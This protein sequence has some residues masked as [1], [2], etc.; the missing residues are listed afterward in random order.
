MKKS[1]V[2]KKPKVINITNT[3]NFGLVESYKALRTNIMFSLPAKENVRSRKI[4][5]TSSG[6]GEGKSTTTVNLALT[7]AETETK[8][9]LIDADMRKPTVHKY[10]DIES[11]VGL[12]NLLSGMNTAEECIQ[13]IEGMPNLSVIPSGIL[14]PN[15]SELLGSS[16]MTKILSEFESEYDYIIIDTPPINVV[17]DALSIVNR[18]DGV[19]FVISQGK[20][21]FPEVLRAVESLK[22]ANANIIGSV[23]NRVS[24]GNKSGNYKNY[25]YRSYG[26]YRYGAYRYGS[27][28][29]YG[30]GPYGSYGH[31]DR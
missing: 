26:A 10:F 11:R 21:T 24:S 16:A 30:Y 3:A 7:L 15:P 4:L 1:E 28:G 22:F 31:M 23:I 8:V 12:S 13:K 29:S 5:F 6:P 19:A 25:R 17:A 20:A 14:P 27:Y 18:V 9:L 2:Q